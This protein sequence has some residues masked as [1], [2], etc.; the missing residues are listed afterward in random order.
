MS[1]ILLAGSL[2][3]YLFLNSTGQQAASFFLMPARFWELSAGSLAFLIHSKSATKARH[4]S[5]RADKN[6]NF[7]GKVDLRDITLIVLLLSVFFTPLDI[8][9]PATISTVVL[10]AFLLVLIKQESWLGRLLSHPQVLIV[11]L[12]SYSLYLWHW[13]V[14]VLARWTWGIN[15]QTIL[16][17]LALI[18]CLTYISFQIETYFRNRSFA[19]SFLSR[20]LL[21]YPLAALFT[22]TVVVMLQGSWKWLLFLGDRSTSIMDSSDMKRILGTKINTVNCFREPPAPIDQQNNYDTCLAQKAVDLPTLFFEGDS[23]TNSIMPLGDKVYQSGRFNVSFFAR[24]GCPFP[25]FQPWT[26]S[27]HLSPRY[28]KCSSHYAEQWRNLSPLLNKGDSLVLVSNFNGYFPNQ[29]QASRV[30]AEAHYAKEIGRLSASLKQKGASMIIFAPMPTF[31]DRPEIAF[32]STTCRQ[33]WYRPAW[34][35]PEQCKPISIERDDYLKSIARFESLLNRLSVQHSNIHIFSPSDT[36]CPASLDQCSTHME[37]EMLFS[38]SN[39]LS[40]YGAIKMYPAFR[41]F[42]QKMNDKQRS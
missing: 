28:Q 32:P 29:S 16:P 21:I 7:S 22:G 11:G 36:I 1:I 4:R 6:D 14:I 33:E 25:Y 24:G 38:D 12:M 9:V 31:A 5:E 10:T 35:I 27:R 41:E 39:H 3:Y 23:H 42:L 15:W 30:E 17:I 34:S 26:G 8:R 2:A 13:P 40:N 19:S 18:A 37:S 20:P